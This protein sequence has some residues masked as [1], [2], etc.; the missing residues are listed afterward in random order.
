[1]PK[2]WVSSR[3]APWSAADDPH[4]PNPLGPETHTA[5][6]GGRGNGGQG[7]G[8]GGSRGGFAAGRGTVSHT[9]QVQQQLQQTPGT[10]RFALQQFEQPQALAAVGEDATSVQN[11]LSTQQDA[12]GPPPWQLS[13]SEIAST[14]PTPAPGK[15]K[16]VRFEN[17]D[18]PKPDNTPEPDE[19]SEEEDDDDDDDDDARITY[20]PSLREGQRDEQ[21]QQQQQQQ[22]PQQQQQ[23]QQQRR[24]QP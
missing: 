9:L 3:R 1:M 16:G 18:A 14:A 4:N 13:V 20:N 6:L 5:G 2:S 7:H 19:S 15:G 23:Q 17:D 12:S 24:Q 11:R 10:P 8:K 21:Q 22:Q